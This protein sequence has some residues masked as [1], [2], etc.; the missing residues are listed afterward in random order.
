MYKEIDI[1]QTWDISKNEEDNVTAQL[2][3][4]EH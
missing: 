4:K 1:I 3:E 2:D